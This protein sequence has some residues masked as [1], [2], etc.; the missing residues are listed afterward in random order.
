MS[1][2]DLRTKAHEQLPVLH[3]FCLL[4]DDFVRRSVSQSVC[5]RRLRITQVR[6]TG[7]LVSAR[8]RKLVIRSSGLLELTACDPHP[9]LH[10]VALVG[11][12]PAWI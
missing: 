7:W 8:I 12:L 9:A 5:D 11:C 3:F 2:Y 4:K 1:S 10:G 6:S